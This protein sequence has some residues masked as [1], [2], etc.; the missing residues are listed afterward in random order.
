VGA[1]AAI[2]WALTAALPKAA[3]V[4]RKAIM[5]RIERM[6]YSAE[7]ERKPSRAWFTH[8]PVTI[9]RASPSNIDAAHIGLH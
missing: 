9:A 8:V 4:L 5:R 1:E 7:I 3:S 6:D 2:G